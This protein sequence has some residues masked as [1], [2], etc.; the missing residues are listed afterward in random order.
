MLRHLR[1]RRFALVFAIALGLVGLFF[2]RGSSA[3]SVYVLHGSSIHAQYAFENAR[4]ITPYLRVGDVVTQSIE[5]LET[6]RVAEARGD[7]DGAIKAYEEAV[8]V[9]DTL[10]YT[11]PPYWYYPVRQSLGAALLKAGKLDAAEAAFRSSFAKTPS[12]GWAL[13]GLMEVYK[14][15]GDT[16]ALAAAR[17]RFETT[18]LGRKDGPDLARL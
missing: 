4:T 13:R 10:P 5:L 15:R 3:A 8:A 6:G 12:N 2:V 17:K 16:A 11:E 7:L 14:Q 18:W 1:S 9:Q